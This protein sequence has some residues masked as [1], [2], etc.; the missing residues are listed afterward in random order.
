MFE[1]KEYLKFLISREIING[2]VKI[3]VKITNKINN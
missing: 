1:E 2:L 3:N